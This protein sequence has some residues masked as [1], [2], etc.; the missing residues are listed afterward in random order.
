MQK[1]KVPIIYAAII[2]FAAITLT[3][4]G[5]NRDQVISTCIFLMIVCGTLFYWKFRLTFAFAGI[6]ALLTTG[7]LD[8][9]HV[10]EH[11]GLDIILFLVG[12][13]CVVGYLEEKRFFEYLIAKVV[14]RIG[15]H[16]YL[17]MTFLMVFAS[18]SAALVD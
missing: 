17:L 11:A 9:P 6:S 5:F 8:V 3:R 14:D 4:I 15:H 10:I 18:I 2:L 12:M 7:L 13:M 1:L 16:A